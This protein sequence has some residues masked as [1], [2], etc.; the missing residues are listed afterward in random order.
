MFP[1]NP[2]HMEDEYSVHFH[3]QKFGRHKDRETRKG[4][5]SNKEPGRG[6]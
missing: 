4:I 3:F 2:L 1:N 5:E 6:Y